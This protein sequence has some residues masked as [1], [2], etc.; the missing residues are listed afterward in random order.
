MQG[1]SLDFL[2]DI[3]RDG[4]R[5]LK[6]NEVIHLEV[7]C[8]NELSV[9]SMFPDALRDEVLSQYLP[10]KRQ[11]SNKLPERAFFYGIL[12]TLRRQYM[13]D[14]IR[15]AHSKRFKAPEDDAKKQSI[16]ISETWMSELTKH[17][18]FSSKR[19]RLNLIRETRDWHIPHEGKG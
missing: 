1:T 19:S 18:Y 8:Y 13:V 9:K 7:P 5:H 2:T 15:D 17:P 16:V 10:S 4:K 11:L 14:V 12:C 6:T 3:L